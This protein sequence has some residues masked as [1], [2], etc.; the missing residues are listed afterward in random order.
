VVVAAVGDDAVRS[1]PR[2]ADTAAY[3][4]HPVEP[5]E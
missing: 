5:R 4:W 2:P 1:P 3:R